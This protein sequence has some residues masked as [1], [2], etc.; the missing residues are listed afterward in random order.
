MATRLIGSALPTPPTAESRL[1]RRYP[2]VRRAGAT[3]FLGDA[4]RMYP[5]WPSPVVV[6]SDGAYGVSGFPGDSLSPAGLVEWY[7]P[8]VAEWSKAA[9]GETTLW[10]WNTEVGWATVHPLLLEHGWEYVGCNV[11]DKGIAHVSGNTNSKTLRRF[12]VVTEVCAQYVKATTFK[13]GGRELAIKEWLRW[14]WERSGLPLSKSN[15]AC[16]V[17]NAANAQV[18]DQGSCMVLPAARRVS[19]PGGLRERSRTPRRTSVL[20][21][22]RTN[23]VV[24]RSLGADEIQVLA[25]SRSHERLVVARRP[26]RGASSPERRL[27]QVRSR[28]S[29]AQKAH[30]A[31]HRSRFGAGRC[32]LGTIWRTLH[33]SPGMRRRGPEVLLRRGVARILCRR[34]SDASRLSSCVWV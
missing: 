6:V 5:D 21:A 14:E 30:V 19:V 28:Q 18:L 27:G 2:S 16:G 34:R 8:H 33:R 22:R 25:P 17:K 4:L 20:L 9:T 29:E 7:R 24:G 23:P 1:S 32:R 13:V 31:H 12:P 15:E 10:F 26:R 3:V 11:W